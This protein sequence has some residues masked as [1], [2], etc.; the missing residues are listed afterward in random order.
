MALSKQIGTVYG[1]AASY[2]RITDLTLDSIGGNAHVVVSGYYDLS[3]R[4]NGAEPLKTIEYSASGQDLLAYFPT[5]LEVAQVY[6][7][8]KAQSEFIFAEDC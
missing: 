1:V 7:F 8:V 3:T 2:W 4:L 6:A 5:G